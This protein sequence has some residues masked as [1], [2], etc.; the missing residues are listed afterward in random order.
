MGVLSTDRHAPTGTEACF[1]ELGSKEHTGAEISVHSI[2]NPTGS[3]EDKKNTNRYLADWC[4]N[5]VR[6]YSFMIHTGI[7]FLASR[8]LSSWFT[9]LIAGGVRRQRGGA[10]QPFATLCTPPAHNLCNNNALHRAQP[11][12]TMPHQEVGDWSWGAVLG[13]VWAP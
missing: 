3:L 11:E 2:N 1:G 13:A 12:V 8:N 4:S 7:L 6:R 10:R 5:R 9:L